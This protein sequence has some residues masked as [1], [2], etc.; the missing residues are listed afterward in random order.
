MCVLNQSRRKERG[1]RRVI[2]EP[3]AK[4]NSAVNLNFSTMQPTASE[5]VGMWWLHS[6]AKA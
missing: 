5:S 6:N 1:P 2:A 4:C 3:C